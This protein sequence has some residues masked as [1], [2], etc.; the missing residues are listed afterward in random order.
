MIRLLIVILTIRGHRIFVALYFAILYFYLLH[1]VSWVFL[2]RYENSIVLLTYLQSKKELKFTH[3]RHLIFL[4]HHSPELHAAS[5]VSTA[6]NNT[7]HI[8][9]THEKVTNKLAAG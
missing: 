3:H 2:L 9:L 6:K 7:I 8:N 5:I 1:T 4:G